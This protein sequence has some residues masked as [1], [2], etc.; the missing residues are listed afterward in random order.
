MLRIKLALVLVAGS[1]LAS[2]SSS[3]D[4]VAPQARPILSRPTLDRADDQQQ[5]VTGQATIILDNFNNASEKYTQSAI[6]HTDGTFSGDFELRSEQAPGIRIHGDVVCFKII[7]NTAYLA[8][9]IDQS[10]D[11]TGAP[12]GSYVLWNIVDNGE[13]ANSPPDLT[14]DFYAFLSPDLVTLQ[15]TEGIDLGAFPVVNGNL[16]V[17]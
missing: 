10:D 16:Q 1:T 15:C 17:H 13:G 7:G 3:R 2:C 14:S 9:V 11:P 12:V 6:R 8:G 4:L 5:Q